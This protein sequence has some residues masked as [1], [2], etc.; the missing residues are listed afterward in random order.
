MTTLLDALCAAN[1]VQGGTIHQ[2]QPPSI[3]HDDWIRMERAFADYR[4]CGIE[5]P[6][7]ASLNKLAR[8]YRVT[9]RWDKS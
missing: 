3:N 9:I 1:G 2:Y 5:F 8:Q 4:K 6:S 7:K